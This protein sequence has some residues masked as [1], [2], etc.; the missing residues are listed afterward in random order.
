MLLFSLD[1]YFSYSTFL[2]RSKGGAF[3]LSYNVSIG[4]FACYYTFPI[5]AFKFLVFLAVIESFKKKVPL[6]FIS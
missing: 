3:A 6:V 5:C 1:R 4:E 2:F